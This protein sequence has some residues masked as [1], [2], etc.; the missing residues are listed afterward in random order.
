MR[1]ASRF[2]GASSDKAFSWF[3]LATPL[4]PGEYTVHWKGSGCAGPN[5]IHE[6]RFTVVTAAP[7]PSKS[8][9]LAV[10]SASRRPDAVL[11]ASASHDNWSESIDA[12]IVTLDLTPDP[13][14][15]AYDSTLVWETTVDGEP[16][17]YETP[18]EKVPTLLE[19]G[20]PSL[21]SA[22]QL[23]ASCDG[24]FHEQKGSV[25]ARTTSRCALSLVG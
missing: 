6:S 8:G 18:H 3:E 15:T 2:L 20:P 14:L 10:K 23:F 9:T 22:R 17:L 24:L 12:A 7:P 21:R 25:S 19:N 5:D 1:R 13:S 16:W 4:S 11:P